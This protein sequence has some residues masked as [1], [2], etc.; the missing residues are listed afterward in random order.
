MEPNARPVFDPAMNQLLIDRIMGRPASAPASAAPADPWAAFPA[1]PADPFGAFPDAPAAS[2]APA[3]SRV[4]DFEGRRI[5]MPG[6]ATDDEVRQVLGTPPAPAAPQASGQGGQVVEVEA[7]DG[8][9]VEFPH[10]T[11]RDVMAK[12]MQA[13]FGRAPAAPAPVA[14]GSQMTPNEADLAVSGIGQPVPEMRPGPAPL[15]GDSLAGI[16]KAAMQGPVSGLD[17]LIDA[18]VHLANQAPKA[19]NLN[20]WLVNKIL[21]RDAVPYAGAISDHP[22]LPSDI[23]HAP[24]RALGSRKYVPQGPVERI[25]DRI[26][27][28]VGASAVPAAG[29]LAAGG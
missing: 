3:P 7:P 20:A 14:R 15:Q 6:D 9:V 5:T 1:A 21:G 8:R 16:G 12:A 4:I 27:Q 10:D 28:E 24:D 17:M 18:P 25:V 2:P 19:L 29:A 26:G 23:L 13:K 22:L 11:P